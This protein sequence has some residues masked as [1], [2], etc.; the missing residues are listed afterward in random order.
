MNERA[1]QILVRFPEWRRVRS[2]YGSSLHQHLKKAVPE[3]VMIKFLSN[4]FKSFFVAMLFLTAANAAGDSEKVDFTLP[5]INGKL[6]SL[7]DF[8]GQWVV[9][10]FWATWCSPCI[11]EIPHL[12]KIA[13]TT[14]PVQP[15]VIGID[16]EEAEKDVLQEFMDQLQMDYLVLIVG[17]APLI[18]FEPLKG[19][20]TTFLV[21]PNREIV[22]DWVGAV[23]EQKVIDELSKQVAQ[24][25]S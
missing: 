7:S 21:S 24:F 20:P 11:Q 6:H 23:T 3:T 5:D 22:A 2:A 13:K 16:F 10:N 12:R 17:E 18:P 9:I 15:V 4:I 25:E 19:L 1:R 14:E 8:E